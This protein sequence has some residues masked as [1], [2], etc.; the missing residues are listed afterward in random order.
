HRAHIKRSIGKG[1]VLRVPYSELR[2]LAPGPCP[3]RAELT[4][5]RINRRHSCRRTASNNLLGKGAISAPDVEPTQVLR[6][7]EPIQ[8]QFTGL[9]APAAHQ[10]LISFSVRG[11]LVSLAH[12]G[13]TS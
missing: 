9:A 6:S 4:L 1:Q 7:V 3:G 10:P 11:E 8:E 2:H 12:G 13:I 5:R